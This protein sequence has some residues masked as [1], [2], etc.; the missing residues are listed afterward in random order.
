MSAKIYA[1]TKEKS[2]WEPVT[3]TSGRDVPG[4][5]RYTPSGVIYVRKTFKALGIPPLFE[6]THQKTLGKAKTAAEAIIHQW[7]NKHLGL[8]DSVVY[9]KRKTSPGKT[10]RDAA[11]WVLENHTPTQRIATQKKHHYYLGLIMD[12]FGD[13]SLDSVT[14]EDFNRWVMRLR[15][16]KFAPDIPKGERGYRP[17]RLRRSFEDFSKHMNLLFRQAYLRRRVSHL[18]T[19]PNPDKALIA[20]RK[21]RAKKYTDSELQGLWSEMSDDMRDQFVLAAECYMRLREALKLSWDRV[22]LETGKV[23]LRPED[24]KTGSK[25]GQGREFLL[26]PMALAR[27]RARHAKSHSPFIFPHR[28]NPN[29][30]RTTNKSAWASAKARA[31]IS[32]TWHHLRH[33]ALSRALLEAEANPVKVSEYAGVSL[34]TVQRNYLHARAE[35][36][37]EAAI[38]ATLPLKGCE[39]GVNGKSRKSQV[40]KIRGK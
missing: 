3:D 11:K 22:D 30:P 10:V 35:D 14:I 37:A 28:D 38:A 13:R 27:I 9:G 5:S 39:R 33:T 16:R 32:G 19:F 31:G 1:L 2:R 7:K 29:L 4:L 8:D 18:V 34:Q 23:T 24:V 6:S 40:S 36:T 20:G 26:S 12:E 15:Q 21:A 17:A 25:T